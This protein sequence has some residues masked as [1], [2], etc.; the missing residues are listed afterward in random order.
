MRNH[1]AVHT[2]VQCTERVR[3]PDNNRNSEGDDVR[4]ICAETPL[5]GGGNGSSVP[6]EFDSDASNS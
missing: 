5:G 3:K 6:L 1:D 2:S 4:G